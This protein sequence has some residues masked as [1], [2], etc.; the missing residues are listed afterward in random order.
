MDPTVEKIALVA[1]GKAESLRRSPLACFILSAL[2]GI[3]V[4]FGIVLIFAI[5][6]APV[7]RRLS[8]HQGPDGSVLWHR[9]EPGDLCRV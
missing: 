5:G 6:G 7:R 9:P 4:G 3:Y 1:A 8:L 2:A